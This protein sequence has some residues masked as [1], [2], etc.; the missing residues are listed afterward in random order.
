M[1]LHNSFY[2]TQL[3]DCILQFSALIQNGVLHD[4]IDQ[5]MSQAW[6]W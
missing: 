2:N 4:L 5:V 6:F 1:Q 3:K